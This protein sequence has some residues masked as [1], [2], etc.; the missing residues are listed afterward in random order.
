MVQLEI[1]LE[2]RAWKPVIRYDCVHGFAHCDRYN[3]KGDLDK[4]EVSLSYA[5]SL[6]FAD[7]DINE[8]WDTYQQR[9]LQGDFP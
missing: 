3:L 7:R 4:Q 5:G 6:D 2:D 8:N 9:F 1:Q